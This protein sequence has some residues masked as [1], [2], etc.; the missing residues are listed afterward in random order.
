[1]LRER[2][3]ASTKAGAGEGAAGLREEADRTAAVLRDPRRRA[4]M[5]AMIRQAVPF[6]GGRPDWPRIERLVAAY[7]NVNVRCLILWGSRDE[8]FPVSMGYKLAAEVPGARLRIV[9]GAMHSLPLEQ[10]TL[11]ATVVRDFVAERDDGGD[12]FALV[13]TAATH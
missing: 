12:R 4:A 11:C 13:Q 9:P 2:V 10:P 6:R 1:L 3:A 8:L 7:P 5:Q